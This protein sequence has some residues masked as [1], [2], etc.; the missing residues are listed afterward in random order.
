ME[1]LIKLFS[2]FSFH[3]FTLHIISILHVVI[4]S[5]VRSYFSNFGIKLNI[6]ILSFSPKNWILEIFKF[7]S[8]SNNIK[9]NFFCSNIYFEKLTFKLKC[10]RIIIS[11]SHGWK[12]ACL[13]LLYRTSILSP[14]ND[15]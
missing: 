1:S 8:T 12:N 15:V 6:L 11:L 14:R 10:K 4:F 2:H 9:L 13:I 7:N 3:L 5:K